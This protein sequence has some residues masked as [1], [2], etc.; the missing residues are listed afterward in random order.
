MITHATQQ[1]I[2][3][4]F[5]LL[6]I[7]WQDMDFPLRRLLD[8]DTF[9]KTMT[10]LMA[11]P[12]SK[13]SYQHCFV[14]KKGATVIGVLFGYFGK[15]ESL[16]D[17][18]FCQFIDERFPHLNIRAYMDYR[19]SL[20]NEWYLDAL[21]VHPNHQKKGIGSAL[22]QHIDTHITTMPI[23]LNCE[24]DNVTAQ[25]LYEKIGFQFV[26]TVSF[27]GHTYHHLQKTKP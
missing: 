4:I 22:L 12:H 13:F 5:P 9:K 21:I 18:H 16:L 8:S 1:D 14:F 3:S 23:G 17:E 19:E 10:D 15:D 26:T 2:P 25:R 6:D 27:L 7:I 11:L 24:H 20:D